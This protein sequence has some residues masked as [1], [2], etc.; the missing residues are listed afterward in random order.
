VARVTWTATARE[1]LRRIA[2]YIS[3]DSPMYARS[4]ASRVRRRVT[5]LADFPQSGRRVPEDR[6]NT[7]REVIVGKHRVIYRTAADAV[8]IVTVLHGARDLRE[9]FATGLEDE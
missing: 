1:D 3:A 6:S 9:R 8:T 2:Q 4:F 5:Q 7:Y